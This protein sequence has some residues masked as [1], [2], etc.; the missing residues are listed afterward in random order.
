MKIKK[1]YAEPTMKLH[2]LTTSK[3]IALSGG[4]ESKP[5]FPGIT[6]D[7]FEGGD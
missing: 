2:K 5:E 7:E 3:M 4:N 6:E 1:L